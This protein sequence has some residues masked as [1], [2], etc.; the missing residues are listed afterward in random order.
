MHHLIVSKL[1]HDCYISCCPHR[2]HLS[3]QAWCWAWWAW[4]SITWETCWGDTS[5]A[6]CRTSLP[7]WVSLENGGFEVGSSFFIIFIHWCCC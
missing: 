7:P 1:D 2:P 3:L 4:T 6:S 5:T